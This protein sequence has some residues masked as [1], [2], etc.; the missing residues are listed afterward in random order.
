MPFMDAQTPK[1]DWQ[2]PGEVPDT[3]VIIRGDNPAA[4]PGNAGCQIGETEW[5]VKGIPAGVTR[6]DVEVPLCCISA[7]PTIAHR[8]G[9][10][11]FPIIG[12]HTFGDA[13]TTHAI[14]FCILEG[15]DDTPPFISAG[16][17]IIVN[18]LLATHHVRIIC[19]WRAWSDPPP[20]PFFVAPPVPNNYSAL[21]MLGFHNTVEGVYESDI[22]SVLSDPGINAPGIPATGPASVLLVNWWQ[23][24]VLFPLGFPAGMVSEGGTNAI[25]AAMQ[26]MSLERVPAG[27]TGD[28]AIVFSA[29]AD[30]LAM[31]VLI[32]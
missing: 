19:G 30:A 20:L 12:I 6:D 13:N 17:T 8:L 4:P 23:T 32:R 29:D 11:G 5:F 1:E 27:D 16:W 14:F 24:G 28:R 21:T 10:R 26:T 25:I 2:Y 15:P 7:I 9:E 22:D 18:Q 3:L 31:S